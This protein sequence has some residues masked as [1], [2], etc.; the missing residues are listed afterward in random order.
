[1]ISSMSLCSRNRCLR[2]GARRR[3]VNQ[4]HTART[5]SIVDGE[6]RMVGIEANDQRGLTLG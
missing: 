4:R 3:P 2:L 1:M 5:I 6:R